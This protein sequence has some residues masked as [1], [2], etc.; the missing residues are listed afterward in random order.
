MQKIILASGSP[1]RRELLTQI[2]MPFEVITSDVKEVTTATQPDEI[3]KELSKIKAEAVKQLC[4]EKGETYQDAVILG[5][6]TIVAYQGRILGKPEDEAAASEML[7]MLSGH[8][9]QVYTGVCMVE[10]KDGEL[11]CHTFFEQ[12]DVK[13]YP[14]SQ[15]QIDAYI[16][17]GESMDKAGSYGIQGLGAVFVESI[18]GDYNNV[19]GLPVSRV[20]QYLYQAQEACQE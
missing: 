1:R 12:T 14:I 20:W 10:R 16:A 11:D 9:H 3:V 19:V 5:A 7:Q 2:G 13:M 18:H 6:D 17:S 15:A 4:K 8:V